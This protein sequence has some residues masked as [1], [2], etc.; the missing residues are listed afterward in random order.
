MSPAYPE[1]H[2]VHVARKAKGWRLEDLASR[3]GCSK[4]LLSNVE[5]GY[6]PPEGRRREIAKA[7]GCDVDLLWPPAEIQ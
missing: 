5:R 2:P 7:L 4:P 1:E 3:V 6:R